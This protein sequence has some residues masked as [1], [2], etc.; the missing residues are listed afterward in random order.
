MEDKLK[1]EK[2]LT[3]EEIA[4]YLHISTKSVYR[5]IK[6]QEIPCFEIA[7]QF[8]FKKKFN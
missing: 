7:H 1:E 6:K 2:L 5:M 8:R 4:E 3:V